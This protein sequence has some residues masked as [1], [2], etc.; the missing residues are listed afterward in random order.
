MDNYDA[1]DSLD[2][3]SDLSMEDEDILRVMRVRMNQALTVAQW[4]RDSELADN[5][6]MYSGDQWTQED[7]QRQNS[8]A[9][10][11]MTINVIKPTLDAIHG[12]AI[13]TNPS[14]KFI[15]RLTNQREEG[16]SDIMNHLAPYIEQ[17]ADAQMAYA[18]AFLD[19]LQCGVGAVE[20]YF[21][22]DTPPHN[23]N[24]CVNRVFPGF[25]FWDPG[26]RAKNIIDANWVVVTRVTD[27]KTIS[28][29]YD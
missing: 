24:V 11:I 17:N 23:G 6:D 26:A 14:M 22:Y 28:D 27:K 1:Y 21:S 3:R 10:P 2:D 16:F 15:P 8:N 7:M 5:T 29:K 9:Q 20:T 4:W 25:T 19:M 18:Y 13:Q 12:M